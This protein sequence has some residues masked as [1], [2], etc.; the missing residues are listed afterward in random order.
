VKASSTHRLAE[1]AY[2]FH[3][4]VER[5]LHDKLDE[6]G[7]TIPLA[8]AI[9]QMDPARGPVSR[10]ELADRLSCDPSNVTFLVRRLEQRR[11]VELADAPGDRRVKPLALTAKGI[12]IRK[13]LITTLAKSD[14]FGH[15]TTPQRQS[16][17][18]LLTSC[19]GN[20]PDTLGR[21]LC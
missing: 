3:A 13:A 8:D 17:A 10:R 18:E 6:L 15:L 5:G 20:L 14:M 21:Q 1:A 12:E 4:A 2:E 11:L 7:L 9:W 16:L 19:A